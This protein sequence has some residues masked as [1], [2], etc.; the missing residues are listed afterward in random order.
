MCWGREREGLKERDGLRGRRRVEGVRERWR[1]RK[2]KRYGLKTITG[3]SLR[4]NYSQMCENVTLGEVCYI[5]KAPQWQSAK[6]GFSC[7]LT[8]SSYQV[9]RGGWWRSDTALFL[10][11]KEQVNSHFHSYSLTMMWNLFSLGFLSV[12]QEKLLLYTSSANQP[13]SSNF[14]K[15]VT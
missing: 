9:R 14:L 2:I 4:W 1:K 5:I 6:H 15:Q 13:L 10:M 12:A 11:L 3:D 8:V 7:S